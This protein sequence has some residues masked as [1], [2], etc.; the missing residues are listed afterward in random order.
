MKKKITVG[1]MAVVIFSAFAFTKNSP[2]YVHFLNGSLSKLDSL[3]SKVNPVADTRVLSPEESLAAFRVPAGFHMELVA[4]EPMIHE[5]VAI[6]WDGNARMYVC[7]MNTYMQDADAKGE[8]DAV[9]RIMLLDDTDGDGKMDKSSVFIDSLSL[10]RMILCTNHELI[11]NETDS[12]NLWSY[13]DS[14]N[15][16]KADIKH[17]VYDVKMAASGN[18]EHQRSGLDWNLDNWIYMTVDPVRLKYK[19]GKMI[20]D[21]LHSG[22]NGQWGLTH[23]NYGKLF[24]SRGGGENAGSGFQINPKYGALEFA[25]AYDEATFGPVWSLISNAD[26]QGGL[27]RLRPDSTLNH[28]TA[29]CG[30]SIYRGDKLGK[31]FQD[32]YFIC[33]PVARIVR[34][35][36][37]VNNHGKTQLENIYQHQEFIASTDFYFRPNNTYTGPDGNLYIVDMSRG[38]VQESQWT[39]KGSWIRSQIN[40]LGLE[41]IK[42]NGRIWRLVKDGESSHTRPNMLN[43]NAMQLVKHLGNPNGWW[44]DNAQKQI[45]LLG[46]KSVIPTLKKILAGQTT[47]QI[48]NPNAL[49]Q[50][51]ALWTLEGLDALDAETA[52]K[53]LSDADAQ[54]RRQAIWAAEPFLIKNNAPITNKIIALSDDENEE[55]KIQTLLSLH[56]SKSTKAKEAVKNILTLHKENPVFSAVDNSLKKNEEYKHFGSKLGRLSAEERDLVLKGSETF[57]AFCSTCHGLDGKGLANKI[58]PPLVGSKHLVE[59]EML[60]KI[61]MNGLSGPIDGITYPT[62]MPPLSENSDEYIASVASYIRYQ[63]GVAPPPIPRNANPDRMY[64]IS[65]EERAKLQNRP[66]KGNFINIFSRPLGGIKVDEVKAIRKD[67]GN[68]NTPWTIE[69][70]EAK[71]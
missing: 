63:F 69:E 68:K 64:I 47:P 43:E 67:F 44:R 42:Q 12:Y 62:I 45:V 16:G 36:R 10:P 56:Q 15:D 1:L 6:A 25:D 38:I 7:E 66:N 33:E 17:K 60:Q 57:K 52:L 28:F 54:V 55:V 14:N 30:Q 58:A 65:E 46:D 39:P 9:S 21:S 22:S 13:K 2:I 24:F 32:N 37:V 59:K 71:R 3:I 11:V 40:R 20:A 49:A 41:K 53:A 70:L 29:G 23:D 4:S 34:R 48:P 26:A 5:P 61:L 50:I 31:E 8:Y 35:A 51:H 18:L 27:R 19:N